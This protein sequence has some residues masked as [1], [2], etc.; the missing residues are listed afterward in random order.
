[1]PL[2]LFVNPRLDRGGAYPARLRSVQSL[3]AFAQAQAEIARWPGF[4]PTP[5]RALPGLAAAHGLASVHY[6][7]EGGRFGLGSFKALGGAYAVMRLLQRAVAD[8]TGQVPDAGA[9]IAGRHR[10]ITRGVTVTCAT[11]GNHGRSVAWGAR[12]FGCACVIYIH[13][14]VSEGRRAAIAA[15]GA[16]VI[17]TDGNYDDSVRQAQA[18]ADRLG[19]LVVSDTS[20]PG[21]RD[22]PREVMQGYS[23][24]A[25]EALEQIGAPPSHVFVQGGVGGAA[26]AVLAHLWERFGKARPILVVVEPDRADCILRSARAGKPVVLTG[27]LD[28]VMAGLSCGEVSELAWEILDPGA[29]G[30]MAIEDQRAIAL[31][32]LLADGVVGDGPI[33]AG[34]SAVAGL[35]GALAARERGAFGLGPNSRLLV[36][37]TEGATDPALYARIVGRAPEAVLAASH[38]SP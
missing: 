6:K 27:D 25:A 31:M 15:Y 1:M 23:I 24:M 36:F 34:E 33:V 11:D 4:A 7:D 30:F 18:D 17:R 10:A 13:A 22:V 28:T 8:R 32:R 5:L 3:D 21:Y 2:D 38:R 37:G 29:D 16:E 26:A 14:G 12:L 19:R 9:L 35:A 20:Y